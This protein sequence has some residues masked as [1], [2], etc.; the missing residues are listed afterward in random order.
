MYRLIEIPVQ[1]LTSI[2]GGLPVVYSS[3][4]GSCTVITGLFN[5]FT[6][7][8]LAVISSTS[9]SSL[10]NFS[11]SEPVADL[12]SLTLTSVTACPA[13]PIVSL[14]LSLSL[15]SGT[16]DALC[17]N[18]WLTLHNDSCTFYILKDG[19]NGVRCRN[20][21]SSSWAFDVENV[22]EDSTLFLL[23][24]PGCITCEGSV[25]FSLKLRAYT[26]PPT[27][28]TLQVSTAMEVVDAWAFY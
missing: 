11:T 22:F 6:A 19:Q 10:F 15:T 17:A 24:E 25:T 7:N 23:G 12:L 4:D 20:V 16:V 2:G 13:P 9:I 5:S 3:D 18:A 14:S 26:L 21:S 27:S 8:S 28:L 1:R